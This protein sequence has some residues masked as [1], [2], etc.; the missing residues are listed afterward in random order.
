MGL[1][2]HRA[3]GLGQAV[4]L[5]EG[6]L[7]DG[8]HPRHDE[9]RAEALEPLRHALAFLPCVTLTAEEGSR[10]RHGRA[11]HLDRSRVVEVAAEWPLPPGEKSWPLA[12]AD[13][14]GEVLALARPWSEQVEGEPAKLVRVLTGP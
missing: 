4:A 9:R 10:L 6:R 12:L 3:G 7:A 14:R 5:D 11:P 13:E 2:R 1:D 8:T